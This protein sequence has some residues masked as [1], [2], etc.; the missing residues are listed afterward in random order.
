VRSYRS[1]SETSGS[2]LQNDIGVPCVRDIN[3]GV[4]WGIHNGKALYE[5]GK[6]GK[7]KSSLSVEVLKSQS[8]DVLKYSSLEVFKY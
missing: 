7:W 8:L 4:G 1:R 3:R 6:D 5:G 2:D